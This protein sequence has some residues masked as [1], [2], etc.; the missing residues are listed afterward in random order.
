MEYT[1][2]IKTCQVHKK[3][4]GWIFLA[5]NLYKSTSYSPND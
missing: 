4:P 3:P 2:L 5:D 1:T